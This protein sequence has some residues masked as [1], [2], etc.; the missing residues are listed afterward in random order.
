M[1][2]AGH[3]P[4]LPGVSSEGLKEERAMNFKGLR[5]DSVAEKW[6]MTP[7][8]FVDFL[9]HSVYKP[10]NLDLYDENDLK[11]PISIEKIRVDNLHKTY[12]L[13]DQLAAAERWIVETKRLY[14]DAL[15]SNNPVDDE[16]VEPFLKHIGLTDDDVSDLLAEEKCALSISGRDSEQEN[17]EILQVNIIKPDSSPSDQKMIERGDYWDVIFDGKSATVKGYKGIRYIAMLLERPGVAV[18]VHDMMQVALPDADDDKEGPMMAPTAMAHGL[19]VVGNIRHSARAKAGV[20]KGQ[21]D[22]LEAKLESP[23]L[24]TER[25]VEIAEELKEGQSRIRAVAQGASILVEMSK[26]KQAA[27]RK[28]ITRSLNGLIKVG[29][30]DM[31]AHLALNIKGAGEYDYRY[32][33]N[34]LWTI[35]WNK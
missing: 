12:F 29:L 15:L 30:G 35:I 9:K 28:A 11:N 8:E 2:H 6:G 33:G 24:S 1:R 18:S 31:G 16:H 7:V 3:P 20:L 22:G 32:T 25:R 13:L 27:V 17:E 10:P 34:S 26:R 14:R 5:A 4:P 23:I 21:M 19:S